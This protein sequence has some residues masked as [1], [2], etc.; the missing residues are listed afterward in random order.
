[1]PTE[2]IESKLRYLKRI[3]Y[4]RARSRETYYKN[5]YIIQEYNKL[6]KLLEG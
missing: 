4:N 1:M 3:V 6:I 5:K 2:D